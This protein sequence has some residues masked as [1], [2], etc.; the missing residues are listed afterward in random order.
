MKDRSGR[1]RGRWARWVGTLV[2]LCVAVVTATA[3]LGGLPEAEA[4]SESERQRLL[5]WE[6]RRTDAAEKQA[7]AAERTARAAERQTRALEDMARRL[8]GIERACGR[9]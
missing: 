7:A 8:A 5:Q 4:Q 1:A 6:R 2:A 9:R 3:M